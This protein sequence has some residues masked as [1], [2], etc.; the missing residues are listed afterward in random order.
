MS[1]QVKTDCDNYGRN[2]E[3]LTTLLSMTSMDF[4]INLLKVDPERRTSAA[5]ALKHPWMNGG[6]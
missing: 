2:G 4:V 5:L 1:F 3:K 6:K